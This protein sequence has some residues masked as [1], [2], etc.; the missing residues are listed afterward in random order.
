MRVLALR[1]RARP[2]QPACPPCLL[3]C[4][5]A[6][7]DLHHHLPDEEGNNATRRRSLSSTRSNIARRS[8]HDRVVAHG[9]AHRSRRACLTC[10]SASAGPPSSSIDE[11]GNSAR[12]RS[13]A[14]HDRYR[15]DLGT[16]AS[17]HTGPLTVRAAM[18][19]GHTRSRR[20]HRPRCLLRAPGG[21]APAGLHQ[22]APF[23][24]ATWLGLD[25][26]P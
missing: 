18:R 9:P 12:R 20:R 10:T 24:P 17:S 6:L 1:V 16:S 4:A 15:G 14:R 3:A 22:L 2:C 26:A 25:Q 13:S 19:L 21:F 7:P 5:P 11:E 8:T 23:E